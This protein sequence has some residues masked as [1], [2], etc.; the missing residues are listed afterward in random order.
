MTKK[1]KNLQ[2][3]SNGKEKGLFFKVMEIV[4]KLGP[5]ISIIPGLVFGFVH[6]V[7]ALKSE[8]FYHVPW[9]Y[10]YDSK[11]S[12]II[13]IVFTLIFL[14]IW[15]APIII[16]KAYSKEEMPWLVSSIYSFLLAFGLFCLSL[17]FCVYFIIDEVGISGHDCWMLIGCFVYAV[18]AFLSYLCFFRIDF[19]KENKRKKELKAENEKE[20]K[21]YNIVDIAAVFYSLVSAIACSFLIVVV[22]L[23]SPL[24]PENKLNY[25]LVPKVQVSDEKMNGEKALEENKEYRVIVSHYKDSVV[26]MDG[27][28]VKNKEKKDPILVIN[29]DHYQIESLNQKTIESKDFS[30]VKPIKNFK[31]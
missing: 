21:K 28:E 29:A 31:K 5:F 12:L 23:F 8:N 27:I 26:L 13:L 4:K 30:E 2:T 16:K 9:F 3:Q 20:A 10:F 7:Y 18:I 25:E 1:K 6:F 24:H 14:F 22:S 17:S 19:N 11:L 15:F